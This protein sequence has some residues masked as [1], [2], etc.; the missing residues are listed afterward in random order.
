MAVVVGWRQQL[1]LEL[2][3]NASSG[4]LSK[5]FFVNKK[6]LGASVARKRPKRCATQ[7]SHA[8]PARTCPSVQ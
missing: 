8:W 4:V 6:A 3:A 7:S 1:E 2:V 5:G